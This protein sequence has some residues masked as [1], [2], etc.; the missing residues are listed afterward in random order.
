VAGFLGG[1]NWALLV[2]C[3]YKCAP[4]HARLSWK[5]PNL[6]MLCSIEEGTLGLPMW[7]PRRNFRDRLHQMPI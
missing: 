2:T 7:D 4:Q 1:I 5:W 6:V 3:I